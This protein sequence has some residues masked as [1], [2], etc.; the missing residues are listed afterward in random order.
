LAEIKKIPYDSSKTD[1]GHCIICISR[2]EH[3]DPL[4]G[5]DLSPTER[6]IRQFNLAIALL[7]ELAHAVSYAITAREDEDFFE[8][9]IVAEAGFE[10][11]A[12]L[13][14]ACPSYSVNAP[15]LVQWFPWP[16]R[17]LLG[18]EGEVESY[19]LAD[20]CSSPRKLEDGV[21][22]ARVSVRFMKNL[23]QDQFWENVMQGPGGAAALLAPEIRKSAPRMKSIRDLLA[24]AD[25]QKASRKKRRYR[26]RR[27]SVRS[28]S[29]AC[30]RLRS[31][32]RCL[33][34]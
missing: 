34:H 21:P 28:H 8:D 27:R 20:L 1:L 16:S 15:K 24:I 18:G 26:T 12:R 6:I 29:C 17:V 13:F 33:R 10:F 11:E 25:E 31:R 23:F 4:R 19:D 32:C 5:D 14:G 30:H 22:I 7:H 3:Y 2:R 9:A